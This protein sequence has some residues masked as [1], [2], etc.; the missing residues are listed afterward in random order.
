MTF[1]TIELKL[2]YNFANKKL[3]EEALT[4]SSKKLEN[5]QVRTYQR[6]EFIGDKTLN[7]IIAQRLFEL[8]PS[9]DE[10]EISR[11]HANLVS[12]FVCTQV[13]QT[14][15]VLKYVI[16]SKAQENDKTYREDKIYEDVLEAIIGAILLDGGIEQAKEF[17][18][19]HWNDYIAKDLNPPKDAKSQL[20]EYF[21]K[22]YKALP[23]YEI[24]HNGE[25]FLAKLNFKS[26]TFEATARTKKEAEKAV[27]EKA[28]EG[29]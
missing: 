26:K 8:F 18:L 12:G 16:F 1:A 20:Q 27:A 23:K 19:K 22:H 17:I 24:S 6:L 7:F 2:D 28:L 15:G 11:R 9:E 21:Q 14:L 13:A 25:V 10:G 29:L 4:H 3:L 5:K